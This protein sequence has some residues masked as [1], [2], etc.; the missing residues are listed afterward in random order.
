LLQFCFQQR[1]IFGNFVDQLGVFNRLKPDFLQLHDLLGR[2]VQGI[3]N[4]VADQPGRQINSLQGCIV[5]KTLGGGPVTL[6]APSPSKAASAISFT[7]WL[8]TNRVFIMFTSKRL[9]VCRRRSATFLGRYFE[10]PG[11]I[12]CF[13]AGLKRYS[14]AVLC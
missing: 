7:E 5:A 6:A 13:Q 2:Q 10:A 12:G 3:D 14:K 11:L 1:Q 8:P 4:S 9:P